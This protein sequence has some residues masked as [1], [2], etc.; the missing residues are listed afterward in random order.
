[1]R[2]TASDR[3]NCVPSRASRRSR[4]PPGS[5]PSPNWGRSNADR[6]RPWSASPPTTP[7]AAAS[8]DCAA[9]GVGA[10]ASGACCTWP[11]GAR[12]APNRPCSSAIRHSEAGA[13][14]PRWPWSPACAPSWHRSTPCSGTKSPGNLSP[15][16]EDSCSHRSRARGCGEAGKAT[17]YSAGM[18]FGFQESSGVPVDPVTSLYRLGGGGPSLGAML[19]AAQA[20]RRKVALLHV[21]IDMLPLVNENM[22]EEVGDQVLAAVAQRLR[23]TMPEEATLWRLCSDEFI[24]CIAYRE[25]EP[26]GEALAE[27]FRDALEGPLSIPPYML[28]VTVS[29]G[30]AVFP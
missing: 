23:S 29:I 21:D 9:S 4:P 26:S 24:A 27:L 2:P 12:S 3:P 28:P 14:A 13:N 17:G 6:T 11:L 1:P 18:S 16:E 8:A 5:R 20:S 25:G 7:T 22:G 15:S 30:I 10:L 19:S